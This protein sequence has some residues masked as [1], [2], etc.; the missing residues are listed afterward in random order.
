MATDKKEKQPFN[1]KKFYRRTALIIYDI[2]SVILASALAIL[3][4]YELQIDNI[5]EHFLVPIIRSLPLVIAVTLVIF[6]I[7]RLYH[8]LWAFAGET[9][10][11]NLVIAC[12]LSGLSNVVILRFFRFGGQTQAV[13]NSYY[14]LY[15]FFLITCIF[16]SRFS[17]RFFRSLKHRN[18]NRNNSISVM[19][20]G[21]GEAANVI[22]KEIL[23]SHFSTMV[24]KCIIDDDKG[25]WGRFIQGIKVVGG[26]ERIIECAELY[27]IDEIII[28]MP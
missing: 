28:A 7:F 25:K 3:V 18:E 26:R 10:L 9:E 16:A 8:S 27:D 12:I 11:Q 5:P 23:V 13:P 24:I 15:I 20:I 21:A 2:L 6:W 17:Y 4:R 14:F 19:V 1:V 22:I